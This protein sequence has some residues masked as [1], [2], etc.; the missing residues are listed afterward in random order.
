MTD[1]KL[2]ATPI[3]GFGR[4]FAFPYETLTGHSLDLRTA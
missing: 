4:A 2:I 1:L 3:G